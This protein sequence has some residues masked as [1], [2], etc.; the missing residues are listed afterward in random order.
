MDL[1]EGPEK[2]PDS[3]PPTPASPN[4]RFAESEAE[5]EVSVC[6]R[7]QVGSRERWV[8]RTGGFGMV[9]GSGGE[10]RRYEEHV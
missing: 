5:L 6:P 3:A 10:V 4:L 7:S 8:E 2:L 9:E 1:P